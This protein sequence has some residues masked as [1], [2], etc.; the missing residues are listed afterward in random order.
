MDST[1]SINWRD[2]YEK[3][4]EFIRFTPD[5]DV[6]EVYRTDNVM[7]LMPK[8]K[9][10]SALDVGCGDGYLCSLYKTKGIKTVEGCDFSKKR[11]D[12]AKKTFTKCK[13]SE[14]SIYNMTYKNNSF[15]LVS[16][17]EV[18]EHLENPLDAIKE[19]ARVSKKY[20]LITVPYDE[21]LRNTACPHCLKI[22]YLDG[23][24]Q[25]FTVER[26]SNLCISA[27]LTVKKINKYNPFFKRRALRWLPKT[28]LDILKKTIFKKKI[29]KSIF[30]GILCEKK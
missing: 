18:I 3:Q 4:A 14:E 20:V 29:E 12:F 22:F 15:D 5:V 19:L 8:D 21:P 2:F 24:I 7:E 16:S 27:N 1:E 13:F 30:L 26:L 23:H 9:I 28:I 17:V 11:I 10:E 6:L 25:R